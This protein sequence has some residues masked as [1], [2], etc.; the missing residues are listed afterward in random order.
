MLGYDQNVPD[1]KGLVWVVSVACLEIYAHQRS[2]SRNVSYIL[3]LLVQ[4]V[5]QSMLWRMR[6]F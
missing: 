2:I 5:M 1:K 6:L 3:T 4:M